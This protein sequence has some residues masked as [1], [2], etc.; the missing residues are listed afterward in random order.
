MLKIE[1]ISKRFSPDV[2]FRA[3]LTCNR[4]PQKPI[5]ALDNIS[6]DLKTGT[7]L[8]ILGPN[9]AGK[10]TLLKIISTLILADQGQAVINGYRLNR[11]EEK[12]KS[13]LG[14]VMDE[15]R[16]FYWRLTGRQNLEFFASLYGFDRYAA[17]ER[18]AYWLEFFKID[19]AD[20]WFYSY[21]TGMKKN[22]AL[23]RGLLHDPQLILFDEPTKSLDY[24]SASALKDFIKNKLVKEMGKT[25]IFTT[26]QIN[27]AMDLADL[28]LILNKGNMRGFGTLEALREVIKSPAA[29]LKRIFLELTRG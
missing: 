13:I 21:S 1:N 20:K 7:I 2:S 29:D 23:I 14:L 4:Q 3:F 22:F 10:T 11:E 26:H 27:E 9:G 18:I 25:V 8:A 19:Y 24:S 16:S 17:R 28:F 15:E 6:F 12:I 5:V